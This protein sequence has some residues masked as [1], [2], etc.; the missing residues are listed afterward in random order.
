MCAFVDY[1]VQR[2]SVNGTFARE[3]ATISLRAPRGAASNPGAV[4]PPKDLSGMRERC[5]EAAREIS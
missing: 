2:G 3:R 4:H 5:G 1:V